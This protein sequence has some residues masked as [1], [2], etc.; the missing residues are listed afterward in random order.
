MRLAIPATVVLTLYSAAAADTHP[1][2]PAQLKLQGHATQIL[3]GQLELALPSPMKLDVVERSLS[4]HVTA[5]PRDEVKGSFE[6]VGAR[7]TMMAFETYASTGSNFRASVISDLP[8]QGVD[9][10]RARIKKL[11]L[12]NPLVGFEVIPKL[13][14]SSLDANVLIYAAYVARANGTVQ[15]LAFYLSSEAL[16]FALAWT[17]LARRVVTSVAPGRNPIDLKAGDTAF[18]RYFVIT[19]PDGW[20]TSFRTGTDDG[21]IAVFQLSEVA[22]LT[23]SSASCALQLGAQSALDGDEKQTGAETN[24]L[25]VKVRWTESEDSV[26]AT[27]TTTI[28]NAWRSFG[29]VITCSAPNQDQLAGL[30]QMI[31]TIRLTGD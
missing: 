6:F 21:P 27:T 5:S 16:P 10:E 14:K 31:G 4:S 19:R 24:V 30:R 13:P 7:F 15:V 12:R 1:V 11:P 23:S 3:G 20:T 26:G 2:S 22:P 18:G 8:T 29:L 28:D 17:S 9:V 25:G